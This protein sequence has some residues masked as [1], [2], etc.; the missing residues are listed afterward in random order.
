MAVAQIRPDWTVGDITLVAGSVDFTTNGSA[1]ET[2]AIQAGDTILINGLVLV[3]ASIT[4]QNSG[5][6]MSPCPAGAATVASPIRIRFQPDGSRYNG[7]TADLIQL[8]TSGNVYSF[9]GLNGSADKIPYFTGAGTLALMDVSSIGGGGGGSWDAVVGTLS[10]RDQYNGEAAGFKVMVVDN[11]DQRSVVYEKTGSGASDWSAPIIFTGPKGNDGSSN[12]L[13]VGSVT[14]GSPAAVTITGQSPNQVINFVLERGLDGEKGDTGDVTPEALAAKDAAEAARDDA[15]AAKDTA[16]TQAGVATS[17]AAEATTAR[18]YA[19][20]WS[21][22]PEGTQVND[23][24]RTGY[25]AYHWSKV[26][27]TAA[28]G[29]IVEINGKTGSSVTLTAADVGA[30]TAAQGSKADT[31]LQTL[32]AGTNI[33]I[34]GSGDTREISATAA[35]QVNSDWNATSGAAEILNKPTLG[36][37]A[38]QNST[39][40]ATAAQGGKADTALQTLT[41]GTN[42]TISGTGTTRTINATV[43]PAPVTSV[44]SKTGAVVISATDIGLGNANNTSDANKPISTAT[45]AALDGKLSTTGIAADSAQLGNKTAAQWQAEIDAKA[46]VYTGSNVNEVNYPIGSLI[47]VMVESTTPQPRNASNTIRLRS[48]SSD[49]TLIGSGN[50]LTGTW[51]AR[52]YTGV[53]TAGNYNFIFQRTL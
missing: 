25:S 30:A 8:L 44:N 1:L 27:E 53:N 47:S 17:K 32:T 3:I 34:T 42:I 28:G 2:A 45:Q 43:P 33:S 38:S 41:A 12:V 14:S 50:I 29:G 36:T 51:V 18:D 21:S 23:G 10:G 13:T 48:T 49:F 31:A 26:A 39:A 5:T 15:V 16:T 9:A 24:V 20:E 6:L 40:F 22:S 52:G 4:G 7:A 35:P 37:A 11:G 19:Y 46:G